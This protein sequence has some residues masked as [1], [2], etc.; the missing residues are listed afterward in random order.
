MH[1]KRSVAV[2][3]SRSSRPYSTTGAN[4]NYTCPRLQCFR[5]G[6]PEHSCIGVVE[7]VDS[8]VRWERLKV[9][10]AA[11]VR[12]YKSDLISGTCAGE[13]IP[14]HRHTAGTCSAPLLAPTGNFGSMACL[15]VM[16][17]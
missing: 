7:R 6:G 17:S 5:R 13:R 9:V 8:F 10:D 1:H 16:R 4:Y 11:E 2:Q 12:S 3:R 15:D 14:L